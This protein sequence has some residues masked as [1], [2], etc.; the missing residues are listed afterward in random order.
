MCGYLS[1]PPESW[2]GAEAECRAS[3][4]GPWGAALGSG[5][6]P[7]PPGKTWDMWLVLSHP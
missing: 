3:A 4:Q 2:G 5:W 6:A 1:P 7:G